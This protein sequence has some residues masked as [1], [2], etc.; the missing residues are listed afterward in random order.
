M[1]TEFPVCIERSEKLKDK[2]TA[3]A[4]LEWDRRWKT[5]EGR[6][7]WLKPEPEVMSVA[8]FLRKAR[9]SRALDLGCGVGRHSIFLASLGF[10]VVALDASPSAI[11]F[12]RSQVKSDDIIFLIGFMTELPIK[13]CSFDYLLAWNVI[14]HGNRSIVRQSLGEIRRVLRPGGFFQ[15]TMLSKSDHRYGLGRKI[16]A[17]TYILKGAKDDRAHPHFYCNATDLAELFA[18]FDFVD[19]VDRKHETA[20]SNHWHFLAKRI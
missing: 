3:T 1:S 17:D 20:G 11:A 7:N 12:T 9:I 18:G 13:H 16:A 15:G 10:S 8:H 19:L 4:Y 14:Y 6:S 5:E 2:K